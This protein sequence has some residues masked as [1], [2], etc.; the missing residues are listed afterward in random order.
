MFDQSKR[1]VGIKSLL[2]FF[3]LCNHLDTRTHGV[4]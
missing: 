2:S 4:R 3:S 1:S